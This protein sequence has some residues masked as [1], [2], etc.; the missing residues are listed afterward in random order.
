[1]LQV[2]AALLPAVQKVGMPGFGLRQAAFGPWY[3]LLDLRRGAPNLVVSLLEQLGE[4]RAPVK[5][6]AL[7][8]RSGRGSSTWAAMRAL[9]ASRSARTSSRNGVRA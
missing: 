4:G 7:C 5:L 1:V 8:P 6:G 3:P 9:S 2:L